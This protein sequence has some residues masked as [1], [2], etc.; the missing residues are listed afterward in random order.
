MRKLNGI[1]TR[2]LLWMCF[3]AF[4][5]LIFPAGNALALLGTAVLTGDNVNIRSGPGIGFAKVDQFSTGTR[6]PVLA[7]QSGWYQVQLPSG[8]TGW[9]ISRYVRLEKETIEGNT[10]Q[11]TVN[12]RVIQSDVSPYVDE[13]SRTM[14][15]IRFVGEELGAT[16]GW[17]KT[18]QKVTLT[19]TGI[20]IVLWVGQKNAQ[21]NG[22]PF[23]M[24]TVPV[25][26]AG[27]TM[28][29]IRFITEAFGGSITWHKEIQ[30][31]A[32]LT[33]PEFRNA[34]PAGGPATQKVRVEDGPI[35]NIRSG[36]GVTY[37]QI[38]RVIEGDLLTVLGQ[39]TD[40]NGKTWYEVQLDG[41][42]KGWIAG[43]LVSLV[44]VP[45]SEDQGTE[46]QPPANITRRAVVIGDSVNIR[47]G[48]ST[49]F[50]SLGQVDRGEVLEILGQQQ[51]WFEVRL[52]DGTQG[53]VAES[54]V[55]VSSSVSRGERQYGRHDSQDTDG[56]GGPNNDLQ[57]APVEIRSLLVEQTKNNFVV[58]VNGTG[59]IAY[60]T[61]TLDE[62]DRFV[63]DLQN[64]VLSPDQVEGLEV[65]VSHQ[66]ISGIRVA[67]FTPDVVRVVI[68][69]TQ[70]AAFDLVA[71]SDGS[72]LTIG[73]LPG[74]LAGLTI[75]I[76]PGHG[77]IQPGGWADPGAIGPGGLY[78]SE[79]VLDIGRK[80]AHLL[81]QAGATVILTRSGDTAL[82][83]EGRAQIAN[84]VQADAFVS[85]HANASAS[86]RQK[87]T[88]VYFYAPYDSPL[89]DQRYTRKHLAQSIQTEMVRSTG[90]LDLGTLESNFKVLRETVIPSVLVETAFISNPAEEKL[91]QDPQFR[92]KIAQAIARGI[93]RHFLS[94]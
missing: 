77:S 6:L 64:A 14:V 27:R 60:S 13:N 37:N 71:S 84:D 35:V 39:S 62:P 19:R 86:P 33:A 68:D 31:V 51:A 89:G 46:I 73:L 5:V 50:P 20:S 47:T 34:P 79:V 65:P 93:E 17:D 24:D 92:S 56:V 43:W 55:S 57:D 48:P 90:L 1:V 81:N 63:V 9:I 25:M 52:P 58:N 54:L 10:V 18:E 29:P 36:P 91:L 7:E 26:K 11:I 3:L 45:P 72:R 23:T 76:D 61:L 4:L 87:G 53:W 15:P 67:Q 88:S 85:I 44:Q 75:V 21:V 30:T 83:L 42:K 2:I 59:P 80:V 32:I 38:D 28:V 41:E 78:E 69:L 8:Q 22:K 70:P 40:V 94:Y 16:V 49:R 12:G 66:I 74:T 82:T